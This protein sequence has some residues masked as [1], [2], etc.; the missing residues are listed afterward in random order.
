MRTRFAAVIVG[1]AFALAAVPAELAQAQDAAEPDVTPN[2]SPSDSKYAAWRDV[3]FTC[4]DLLA[5][6]AAHDSTDEDENE[7]GSAIFAWIQAFPKLAE[8]RDRQT[9]PALQAGV[10]KWCS[11]QSAA[12]N[13]GAR[14]P[15]VVEKVWRLLGF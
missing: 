7:N 13:S 11:D 2:L 8:R 12:G 3:P 10:I 9:G 4:R 1:A 14:L 15:D 6:E 5:S